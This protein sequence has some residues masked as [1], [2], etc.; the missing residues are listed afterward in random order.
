M[1]FWMTPFFLQAQGTY[2]QL[3]AKYPKTPKAILKSEQVIDISVQADSL[4]I[5]MDRSEEEIYLDETASAYSDQKVGFSNFFEILD[6]K[7][8]SF[9]PASDGKRGKKVK[10][11]EIEE[12]MSDQFFYDD[13]S[14]I[15]FQF[16]D[17]REGGQTELSYKQEVKNRLFIPG[18]YFGSWVPI[19]ES[20]LKVVADKGIE[21]RFLEFNM[22]GVTFDREEKQVGGRVQH[23]YHFK[24][25]EPYDLESSGPSF[26]KVVPHVQL[27][28]KSFQKS[29]QEEVVLDGPDGLFRW[30]SSLI[31]EMDTSGDESMKILADSITANYDSEKDKV[32]AVFKWVQGNINYIAFEDEMGGFIPRNPQQVCEKRYGDCKDM[33]SIIIKLLDLVGIEGNYTWVGTRD[34]PYKYSEHAGVFV[35]N[36]MIA[37]YRGKDDQ[38]YFLDAT[39]EFLPFGYP[40]NFIQG[41]QVMIYKSKDSYELVDVPVMACNKSGVQERAELTIQGDVVRGKTTVDFYGFSA[42]NHYSIDKNIQENKREKAYNRLFG[43]GNNKCTVSD[44]ITKVADSDHVQMTMDFELPD[45]VNQSQDKILL[46]MNLEKILAGMVIEKDRKYALEVDNAFS[47]KREYKL[48]I[49]EGYSVEY[50]PENL[51]ETTQNVNLSIDYIVEGQTVIYNLDVCFDTI[52]VEPENFVD[53]RNFIKKIKKGYRENVVLKKNN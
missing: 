3:K 10:D 24:N 37:T 9:A 15:K 30:Y 53:Y 42:R 19:L 14:T 51:T 52:N 4:Y 49:P 25:I 45:Y 33:S 32:E 39:D 26:Q 44:V 35:D 20:T 38:V 6:I 7:A 36:H 5:V 8:K 17:L 40:S 46:N 23:T 12:T 13:Q 18:A 2:E 41:K 31:D 22:E 21:I 34:L 29:G 1:V 43:K 47:F 48:Q 11:F 50:I 16:E 28:V 27:T